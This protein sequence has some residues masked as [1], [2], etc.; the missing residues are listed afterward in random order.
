[1]RK[2]VAPAA[3]SLGLV[4]LVGGIA[5]AQSQDGSEPRRQVE[6]VQPA[7]QVV[8]PSPTTTVAPSPT[9]TVAPKVKPAP[10]E[11]TTSSAPKVQQKVA[12]VPEETSTPTSA[13]SLPAATVPPP[14][15]PPLSNDEQGVKNLTAPTP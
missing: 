2:F 6:I 1:M 12:T 3:L 14:P 11:S 5:Y 10:V 7:A 8:T 15:P 13:E 9:A 4:G